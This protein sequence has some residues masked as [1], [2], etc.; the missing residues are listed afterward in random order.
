MRR[1][2]LAR[3]PPCFRRVVRRDS[4]FVRVGSRLVTVAI[5]PSFAPAPSVRSLASRRP[6]APVDA[7]PRRD[8]TAGVV[9]SRL[10]SSRRVASRRRR[11]KFSNDTRFSSA[12][13]S[14]RSKKDKVVDIDKMAAAAKAY[15]AAQRA[16]AEAEGCGGGDG[17]EDAGGRGDVAA[18]EKRKRDGGD[19]GRERATIMTTTNSTILTDASGATEDRP[20]FA[21]KPDDPALLKRVQK[22]AEF[23]V[24]NGKKF[25]D[26]TREKQRDNRVE[27]SFL[28]PGG[29][30]VDYYAWL[31]H[32]LKN[33]MNPETPPGVE[34]GGG[35]DAAKL[36]E[37]ARRIAEAAAATESGGGRNAAQAAV[38]NANV[39][40]DAKRASAAKTKTK[41]S[42]VVAAAAAAAPVP[43]VA[44]VGAWQAVKDA[45]GKTYYWNKDTGA[46]TWD[47]P[48]GFL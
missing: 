39:D 9:S 48:P 4:S 30:G 19:D 32:C 3:P 35:F 46:T 21:L 22:V 27:F 43:V 13:G 34:G 11:E 2:A 6:I 44:K 23:V 15:A 38:T 16:K 18:G 33:G 37:A 25:E 14:T 26:V 10:V 1:V 7:P 17:G 31:K 36:A 40:D 28:W 41:T 42:A 29:E 24:K 20:P 8:L 47:P 12:I 45:E 5:L